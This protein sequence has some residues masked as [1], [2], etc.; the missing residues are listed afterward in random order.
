MDDVILNSSAA[1]LISTAAGSSSAGDGISRIGDFFGGIISRLDILNHPD[2]L[3]EMLTGVHVV[4]AGVLFVVGILC[5]LNGYRWH[6]WVIIISAFLSGFALGWVMSRHMEQPYIVAGAL[7]LMAA[8]IANPL[9]R[10]AVAIFGG[11]TG[12]FIGSNLWTALGYAEENHW[13]G[14]LMGLILVGMA[15]FLMSRHVI[16]LFTSIGGG[17]L[18]VC[19]GLSLLLYVPAWREGLTS[20]LTSNQ[21]VIPLLI[22]VAAVI[23]FTIQQSQTA[24]GAAG[25]APTQ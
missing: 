8:V 1:S 20:A 14:A 7:A 6:R 9:L 25:P 24:P 4:V 15:S 12:A 5:I 23:G 21:I 2:Q 18:V 19:G 17:A 3:L 16:M 13:A 10:F 11:V 22:A